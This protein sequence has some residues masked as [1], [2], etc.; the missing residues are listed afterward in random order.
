MSLVLSISASEEKNS[1]IVY[2]CTNIYRYDNLGG[3]NAPNAQIK[4]I[5]SSILYVSPPNL[6]AGVQPY[7]I[8]VTG[9]FPNV[10][11]KGFE[12]LPYQVG[13]VNNQLASGK[14]IINLVVVGTDNTGKEYTASAI[15]LK[16]FIKNVTCCID[17][18]QKLVNKDAHKDKKQQAIIE[19]NEL[20]QAAIWATDCELTDQA[21][22]IIDLLKSQCICIDC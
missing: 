15:L 6:N 13:Q 20:L 12:I 17:K 1:F 8:D 18:L 21:I 14:Y 11:N 16:I 22:E 9:I 3:W 4:N 7:A 19:L 2:D 10:E 5:T